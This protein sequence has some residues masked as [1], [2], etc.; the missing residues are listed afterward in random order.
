MI[1]LFFEIK[2]AG[3]GAVV[4]IDILVFLLAVVVEIGHV[5]V[6]NV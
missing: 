4:E 3:V 2:D 5:L 6:R 1:V